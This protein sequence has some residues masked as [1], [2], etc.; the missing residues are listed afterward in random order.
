MTQVFNH[1]QIRGYRGFEVVNLSQLGQVNIFVGNN[2]SGKT[3]L[4]EAI[5][6]LCNPL[7]PFQWLEVSQ[8]RLYLGRASV[9]G[10][11]PNLEAVKW[12][13]PQKMS[14]VLIEFL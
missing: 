7:D 8:R 9:A 6:I 14:L 4:L 5:S 13:F 2:N 10:L 1:L 3:S 12:M 11:R